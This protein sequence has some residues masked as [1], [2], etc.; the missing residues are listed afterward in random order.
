MMADIFKDKITGNVRE[1][2]VSVVQTY[3]EPRDEPWRVFPDMNAGK[4]F[5][6]DVQNLTPT[7][8]GK[9]Y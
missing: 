4:V 5:P 7:N 2:K 1:T 9:H 8:R 6:K 3:M